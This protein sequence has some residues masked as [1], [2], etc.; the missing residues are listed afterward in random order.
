MCGED[1]LL[2]IF[3]HITN[4]NIFFALQNMFYFTFSL[5]ETTP[6]GCFA[7][8][9][10][11]CFYCHSTTRF[12]VFSLRSIY[13]PTSNQCRCKAELDVVDVLFMIQ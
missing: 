12:S 13:T 7:K 6:D 1:A 9:V 3:G 2:R 8:L 5:L 10:H 11:D 4:L